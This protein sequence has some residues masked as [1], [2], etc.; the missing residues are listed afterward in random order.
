MSQHPSHA[1]SHRHPDQPSPIDVQKAL[2]GADYP[3]RK[4]TLL[5]TARHNHADGAVIELLDRLPDDQNFDSPAAVS[6]A[7]GQLQ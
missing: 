4:R 7:V 2:Q 6:K 1:Q 5:E 3:T